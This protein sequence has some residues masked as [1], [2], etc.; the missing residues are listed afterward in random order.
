MDA[1]P[2]VRSDLEFFPVY[3][4]GEQLILIKDHLGLVEEGK[5]VPFALYEIMALLDG[6]RTIRDIQTTLMRC[7]G[8]VLVGHEEVERLVSLLE[9]S[10]ILDTESYRRSKDEIVAAFSAQP[11]RPCSHCGRSYPNQPDELRKMLEEILAKQAA[12]MPRPETRVVAVIAPH[13]DL[14]V[15]TQV[16]SSAY[17]WLK[18]TSPSK[19]VVLGVGHQLVD[20]LFCLT[21][22]DFQTP[23]GIVKND[24]QGVKRLRQAGDRLI[25]GNDFVHRSEHSLEFQVIFFQHLLAEGSYDIIPILCGPVSPFISAYTRRAYLETAGPFLSALRDIL[26]E[27]PEEILVVAGVDFS[28]IGP[29]FGHQVPASHIRNQSE[30]HDRRLLEALSRGDAEGFWEESARVQDRFNVCGFSALAC[31]MEVLPSCKGHILNYR[32]WHEEATRSAVSFA[33]MAFER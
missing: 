4:A 16:Y 19:I 27:R 13:I 30:S 24:R 18:Q 23:L 17:Q 8:G 1:H 20:G 2:C 32:V 10:F 12:P 25:S 14:G 31:L 21:E 28:H 15:G 3:H 22:K 33:A 9:A 7:R 5:A 11:L 29:K 6:T 26:S